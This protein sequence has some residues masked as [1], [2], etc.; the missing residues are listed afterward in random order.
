MIAVLGA[1]AFGAALALAVG[2]DVRLW[3]RGLAPGARQS[4]RL[5][6]AAFP[7]RVTVVATREDALKGAE[8]VLLAVPMAALRDVA[9]ELDFGAR[10][11]IACCKGIDPDTLAGP[12]RVLLDAGIAAPGVLT[13]PSFAADIARGLPTALTLAL[14]DAGAA[15]AA[16]AA[17]SS[18][19][20]RIYTSPDVRGAELGGALKNV[21][22]IGAGAVV[23]AGLGQSAQA[24]LLTRG[25]AEI[26][27]LAAAEADPATL[28]GL[29]GLGDL[30]LTAFSDQSR[31]FRYGV[32]LGAGEDLPTGLT[33]EG[34]AT[35]RAV[36]RIARDRG[37]DLPVLSATEALISG[38]LTPRAA[39]EALMS[40]PL[41]EE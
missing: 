23:G 38:T 26:R 22:A 33:V 32:A 14:A 41:K 12:S 34:V 19:T 36:A 4:T 15:R 16:Q 11:V 24:A 30:M 2:S 35:A 3:G 17:L 5:P 13:G 39:V 28:V 31:N 6:G 7:D 20:L 40:R 9:A 27:E 10:T 18:S 1:G 25:F 21:L 29:S 37:L 8:I